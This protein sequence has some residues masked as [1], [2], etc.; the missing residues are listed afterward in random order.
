MKILRWW[1]SVQAFAASLT[2]DSSRWWEPV[3]L[4]NC[5]LAWLAP[6]LPSNTDKP[7]VAKPTSAHSKY[8]EKTQVYADIS[9]MQPLV[10]LRLNNRH[11]NR[12]LWQA[13]TCQKHKLVNIQSCKFGLRDTLVL[14]SVKMGN[15]N[16]L[17]WWPWPSSAMQA[18]TTLLCSIRPASTSFNSC[19]SIITHIDRVR[20]IR[21]ER[22][23][24]QCY[25]R[26]RTP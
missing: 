2:H 9:S 1:S 23:F 14:S 17:L 21:K 12:S 22:L 26:Y 15:G 6:F 18:A 13:Q 5:S 24:G 3:K 4:G 10:H 25:K 16:F 11:S 19:R 8:H 20:M 7:T